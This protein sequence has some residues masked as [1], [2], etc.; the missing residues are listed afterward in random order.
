MSEMGNEGFKWF[1]GIAEDVAGDEHQLYRVK[2]RVLS[3]HDDLATEDLPWASVTLPTTSST[4]QGAS[5]T[6]AIAA[7]TMVFGF[8]ADGARKQMP[9]VIATLPIA[10]DANKHSLSMLARGEQIIEKNPIGPE[11]ESSY[12][13]QYPFN[14]VTVSRAG[15]VIEVDDTP[16]AERLHVYHKSGSYVEIAPDGTVVI[17]SAADKYDITTGN[18]TI[19]VE[20]DCTIDAKKV[21]FTGEIE[22]EE[23]TIGGIKFTTHKHQG[24]Q[25]G[26][27]V[28]GGPQ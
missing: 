10:P 18:S 26:S 15:H 19:Y 28:S 27:G 3:E 20:G 7:G 8:F 13:A 6:P 14:K 1:F 16:G 4:F 22:A 5:D 23:A 2:V 24:V 17:K 12:A 11:P 25:P 21:K 9:I